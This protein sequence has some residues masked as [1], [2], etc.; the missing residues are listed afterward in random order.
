M[1][2]FIVIDGTDYPVATFTTLRAAAEY[3]AKHGM[4]RVVDMFVMEG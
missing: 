3:A 1:R 4:H 2:I